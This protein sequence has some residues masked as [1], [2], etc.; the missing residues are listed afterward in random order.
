MPNS[1]KIC[2]TGVAPIQVEKRATGQTDGHNE[3][4]RRFSQL[5]ETA[6]KR[7]RLLLMKN[8]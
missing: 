8:G 5:Y 4:K 2:P 7:Q 1:M 3:A 6:Y